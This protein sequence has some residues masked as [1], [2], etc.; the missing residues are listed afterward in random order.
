MLASVTVQRNTMALFYD[1]TKTVC[2]YMLRSASQLNLMNLLV[3]P[4]KT[5]WCW[6]F[7]WKSVWHYYPSSRPSDC[8]AVKLN[9]ELPVT[10]S[11]QP[12]VL[13][14]KFAAKMLRPLIFFFT[15]TAHWT[16]SGSRTRLLP[17]RGEGGGGRLDSAGVG[18]VEL[19][20]WKLISKISRLG[21][22]SFIIMD[23]IYQS[24]ARD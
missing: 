21:V 24:Q 2:Q 3:Q 7:A 15:S 6:V 16:G 23:Q 4:T 18:N 1:E 22:K 8:D 5:G 12:L 19:E 11:A 10:Q 13:W 14:L 9:N 17:V 20:N